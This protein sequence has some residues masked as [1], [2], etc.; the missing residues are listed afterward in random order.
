MI[1]RNCFQPNRKKIISVLVV[2]I[3]FLISVSTVHIKSFGLEAAKQNSQYKE[4]NISKNYP[5]DNKHIA[6]GIGAGLV[7]ILLGIF[8]SY[9]LMIDPCN[10]ETKPESGADGGVSIY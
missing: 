2:F 9:Q 5:V 10:E 3:V 7:I 1:K 6:M 4:N 8:L